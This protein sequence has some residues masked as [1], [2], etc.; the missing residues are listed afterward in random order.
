MEA[1]YAGALALFCAGCST[2][3]D[4]SFKGYIPRSIADA[5]PDAAKSNDQRPP[6]KGGTGDVVP[7]GAVCSG[8]IMGHLD[9]DTPTDEL[10]LMMNEIPHEPI[11]HVPDAGSPEPGA[12]AIDATFGAAEPQYSVVLRRDLAQALPLSCISV[13]LE[14]IADANTLDLGR[15]PGAWY[16]WAQDASNCFAQSEWSYQ[17]RAEGVWYE[18]GAK[19]DRLATACGRPFDPTSVNAFGFGVST[20]TDDWHLHALI[21]T[22]RWY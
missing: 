3:V 9:F 5:G 20:H 10:R 2:L 17:L 11:R 21:D 1:V 14:I 12:S 6:A 18:L 13:R 4:E 15:Y 22:L 7:L 16:I 19:V 8:D